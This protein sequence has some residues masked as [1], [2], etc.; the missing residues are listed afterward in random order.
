MKRI[1]LLLLGLFALTT[2]SAQNV[3]LL[4]KNKFS[5]DL[6]QNRLSVKFQGTHYWLRMSVLKNDTLTLA[7]FKEGDTP[8]T[9]TEFITFLLLPM[10][11]TIDGYLEKVL[12]SSRQYMPGPPDITNFKNFEG[13]AQKIA[14][15][16]I[17]DPSNNLLEDDIVRL[18]KLNGQRLRVM[19]HTKRLKL[20]EAKANPD[21]AVTQIGDQRAQRLIDVSKAVYPF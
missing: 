12:A 3:D 16:L 14:T 7:Y 1:T 10:S 17:Q 18:T 19:V 21:L 20:S 13:G 11:E 2:L 9:A 5:Y 4:Y 6:K 8:T 15:S